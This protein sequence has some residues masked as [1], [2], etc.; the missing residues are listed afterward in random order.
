MIAERITSAGEPG[1]ESRLVLFDMDRTLLK[2]H[3][4]WEHLKYKRHRGEAGWI[5]VLRMAV[6][7]V[8]YQ[9]GIIDGQKALSSLLSEIKGMPEED[10]LIQSSVWF[11][12][13]IR[14]QISKVGR[15]TVERHRQAN[16][17]C[18]IITSAPIYAAIPLA[19][20]LGIEHVLGTVFATDSDG[21]F[22]GSLDQP[23]CMRQE[24]T[25]RAKAFTEQHGF[26]LARSTFYTDSVCDLDLLRHVGEPVVVNPDLR[27]ARHAKAKGWKIEL[28]PQ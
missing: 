21:K 28:W 11:E 5:D 23:V 2:C 3:T 24:K 8:E 1:H 17:T 25:V 6:K 12:D 9:L 20:A 26:D 18:A 15:S 10:I 13:Q 14:P 16:E 7:M 27:L 4:A 19:R 22:T